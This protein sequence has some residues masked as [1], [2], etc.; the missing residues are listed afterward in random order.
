MSE[1]NGSPVYVTRPFLPPLAELLPLLEEIWESRILTNMGP[2]H[3]RFEAALA[4]YLEVPY[5]SLFNNATNAL[6]VA[7]RTLKAEGEVVTTPFSFVATAH[8]IRWAGSSVVF[9]D[10]DPTTFNV[11]ADSIAA[12]ITPRTVAILPVHCY[13]HACDVDRIRTLGERHGLTVVYDAAHAFGVKLRGESLLKHGDLAVL[14]F[15][16]TKV[17][18]TFEGGAIVSRDR[19]T[20]AQIDRLRNFGIVDQHSVSSVGLNGKLNELQAAVGLVQLRHVDDAIAKRR[21][22]DQRYRA[23][24]ESVSGIRPVDPAPGEEPNAAYFP[25]VIQ[26][27]FPVDRDRLYELLNERGIYSR[28]YFDPLLS[29][30]PM[31]RS[32]PS[33]APGNLPNAHRM[34]RRVL[35]LPMYPDIS[36]G[37]I[38]RVI[39]CLREAQ[40]AR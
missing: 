35:C 29:D 21:K 17:F 1:G 37:V 26:D 9:A 4:T 3:E 15:H 32:L 30:L 19:E 8:T 5:V 27:D 33:A 40:P 22:A 38:A 28:K 12:A 7:L 10:V 6:M 20:K 16:A 31:Y 34:A 11:D 39:A 2:I 23:L 13:G 24:L 18:N 14:S 25:V 36:D